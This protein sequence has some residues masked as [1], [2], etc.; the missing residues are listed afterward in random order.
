MTL[1]ANVFRTPFTAELLKNPH[2]VG[3]DI[4]IIVI[5]DSAIEVEVEIE[6]II[7]ERPL[8]QTSWFSEIVDYPIPNKWRVIGKLKYQETIQ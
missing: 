5:A 8:D 7:A 2:N 6:K 1:S 4:G 3:F